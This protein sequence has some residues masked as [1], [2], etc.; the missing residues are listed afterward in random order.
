MFTMPAGKWNQ[1]KGLK[2]LHEFRAEP[3]C[4]TIHE[5]VNKIAKKARLKSLINILPQYVRSFQVDKL[6]QKPL[7]VSP[8]LFS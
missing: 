7:G 2:R 1:N 6:S 5:N 8:T 4:L 3:T